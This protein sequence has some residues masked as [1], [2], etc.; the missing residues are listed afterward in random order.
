MADES[1]AA[2]S[3][4]LSFGNYNCNGYQQAQTVPCFASPSC[5]RKARTFVRDAGVPA[6]FGHQEVQAGKWMLAI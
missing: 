6:C 2:V 5:E 1:A 3:T 4:H